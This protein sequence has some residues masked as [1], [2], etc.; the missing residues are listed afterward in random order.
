MHPAPLSEP[1]WVSRPADLRKMCS[2][3]VRYGQLAVDTESN[4]LYAYQEQV[5][6]I[7]FST[8]ETD[9]L[10]DSLALSD[11]SPLGPIFGDPRIEKIFH[12]AEYDVL[13][14][15][16]D[17]GF[18][19]AN[20]FDTM[21]AARILG[22]KE[23]GLGNLLAAEFDLEL[24][25]RHQRANWGK[26]P[27]P[28]GMLS[29]ARLDTH[30]LADLRE[31]MAGQLIEMDRLAL[32]EEDF[33]RM[34]DLKPAPLQ[35]EP[36][37]CW[38]VA[39]SRDV[40]PRQAAVLQSLVEFRSR[41]ARYANMPPFKILGNETLLEI[42]TRM[43]KT[44]EDLA[45]IRGLSSGAIDRL[46]SDLLLAVE[47]GRQAAPI[48]APRNH[49]PPEAV[50]RRLENLRTWRKE[51]AREMGVESDV[52]L[53]RETLTTIATENPRGLE[54]L[55]VVMQSL[56]WRLEHFGAQILQV[57]APKRKTA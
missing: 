34:C 12:A 9:Y 13:C 18:Q 10:V 15:K 53:P 29:Y 40:T 56:P 52:I 37:S 27:L 42:V 39:G 5:C 43:P 46:G 23:V 47:R 54:E 57:L 50:V 6:L 26:R 51:A 55:A 3:L 16:R 28:A 20:L 19:F 17:F 11:L 2:D 44:T 8:G 41:H 24:D 45:G 1:V 49:R 22:R 33:Q 35:T 14:L 4:G 7:Q 21:L 25:K 30:Y 36:D 48:H 38:N 31:R 32:A